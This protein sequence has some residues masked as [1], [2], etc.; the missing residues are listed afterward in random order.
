MDERVMVLNQIRPNKKNL[1]VEKDYLKQLKFYIQ[2][3]IQK[4]HIT[5]I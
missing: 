3:V 4:F 5:P 2:N 1:Y